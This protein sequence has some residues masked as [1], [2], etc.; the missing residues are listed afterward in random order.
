MYTHWIPKDIGIDS[1]DIGNSQNENLRVILQFWDA[2]FK[3]LNNKDKEKD[4]LSYIESYQDAVYDILTTYK[5]SEMSE[6]KKREVQMQ[7]EDL[8]MLF[9]EHTI[10][11]TAPNIIKIL[12][13][14]I[15]W[16]AA[17]RDCPV[18]YKVPYFATIQD[19]MIMDSIKVNVY[20]GSKKK[21]R[22]V[23]L[24]ISSNKRDRRK[25]DISTFVNF[26]HQR[27]AS[28]AMT[29]VES[30]INAPIYTVHDNFITT[31]AYSREIPFYYSK[32]FIDMGPPLA[33]L[34]E[35]IYLNLINQII[36]KSDMK[37]NNFSIYRKI[38]SEMLTYFLKA[39]IPEKI[40]KRMLSTWEDRINGVLSSYEEY[41]SLVATPSNRVD[42]WSAHEIKWNQF[43][44]MLM[45]PK[46]G[47]YY[48]VHH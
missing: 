42:C 3:E 2:F 38:D 47:T 20:E 23:T 5:G 15:G 18:I 9:D 32:I 46:R 30:M 28:I 36:L 24:R 7:M 48:C 31:A 14:N 35:F 8:T 43:R 11:K 27:D 25:S 10:H 21:R 34:N 12:I 16:I 45:T 19:Y 26:V 44:R 40:S 29:L 22:Q 39:N 33:I 17:A 4:K 6:E 37:P 41:T 1:C 13:R